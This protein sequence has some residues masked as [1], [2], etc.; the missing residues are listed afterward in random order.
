MSLDPHVSRIRRGL[1]P[2]INPIAEIGRRKVVLS[3]QQSALRRTLSGS[4]NWSFSPLP[5]IHKMASSDGSGGTRSASCSHSSA[6][7]V[8]GSLYSHHVH[9][10][11]TTNPTKLIKKYGIFQFEEYATTTLWHVSSPLNLAPATCPLPKFKENIPRFSRNNIVTTNEHPVEFSNACHNIGS[12]DNNTCMCLFVNFLEGKATAN[13]FDLPPKIFFTWEELVYWFKS[14]YEKSKI[15]T[16]QLREYNNIAYKDGETIKSFNLCFTKLYNQILE[17]IQPHN[18]AAFMHYYNELPSP[19][20]HRIEEKSIDNLGSS[21][22]T[23]LEYEEQLERTGLPQG[24][25]VKHI[26]MYTLLHLLQDMN[27]RMIAYEKKGNVSPLTPGDSSSSAPPFR[28]PN[29]N[30][31]HSKS[32]MPQSWCNFCEEHDEET[33]CEVKKSAKDNIFGK[34]PE[35]TIVVVDFAKPKY[36]IIINNRNKAY[37]PKGKYDPTRNSSS[38]SSSSPTTT[39]QVPKVPDSQGTT[40][41]LPSSKYN[42]LNQLENIKEDATLLYMVVIHEQQRHLKQFMEGKTFVESNISKD[43]GAAFVF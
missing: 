7:S 38:P 43:V 24:E 15:P 10:Q 23:F 32:I 11:S 37:S 30:H 39:I 14:S 41:P 4:S 12:N 3:T 21:L 5:I 27:N 42:I 16:E 8:I 25:L 31:F 28:N 36:V 19:Y 26:D 29:E 20:C 13:F 22:H 1:S 6:S 34:R 40:S 2:E 33:T 17:L 18:Q 9:V 35:T